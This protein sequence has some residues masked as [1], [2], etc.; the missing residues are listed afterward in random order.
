MPGVVHIDGTARPHLVRRD[1]NRDFYALIEAFKK[2]TGL[3]GIINTSF[4]MHE[5]PIVCSAEDA[6]RAFLEGNL[7]FLVLGSHLV[8]HP[9]GVNHPMKAVI[10]FLEAVDA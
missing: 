2:H 9:S 3:P 4:N 1:R 7:D 6:V 8:R 5:E 10:P